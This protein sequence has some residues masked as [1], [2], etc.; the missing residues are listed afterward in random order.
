VYRK[1]KKIHKYGLYNTF[2]YNL[3]ANNYEGEIICI[4]EKHIFSDISEKIIYVN[5]VEDAINYIKS[6]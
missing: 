4:A 5:N 2:I 1:I 3:I 6:L